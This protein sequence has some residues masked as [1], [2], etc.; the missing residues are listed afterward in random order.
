ATVEIGGQGYNVAV[1]NGSSNVFEFM[2][3]G[4]INDK[5]YHFIEV[6]ACPGGCVNG[7][8]QPH[9]NASDRLDMDIR[10][11]RASVLYNQDKNLKKRKSHENGS[12][13]KMYETYMGEPGTGKAH[14]L[15]HIK[16]KK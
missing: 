6:M 4:K 15:L 2:K 7:G 10:S 12:L 13:N 1:I 8:G 16:Y 14:E 3:S 5:K 11:I 9:V